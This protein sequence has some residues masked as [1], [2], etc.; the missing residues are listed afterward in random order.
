M[1]KTVVLKS[2]A[3]IRSTMHDADDEFYPQFKK[4]S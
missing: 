2:L 1:T 4:C 3:D